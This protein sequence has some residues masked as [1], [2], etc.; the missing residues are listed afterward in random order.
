VPEPKK[1]SET[2]VARRIIHKHLL[3]RAALNPPLRSLD[4]HLD[5]DAL[6]VFIEGRLS[7]RESAPILQHL[8]ACA[9]CRHITAQLVR[10][11]S[12]IEFAQPEAA[13]IPL[14]TSRIRG[15]LEKLADRAAHSTTD[16][17]VF[18]Y[19]DSAQVDKEMISETDLSAND[20]DAPT[21]T[22]DER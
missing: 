11:E 15:F 1:S 7:E 9:S 2:E 16:E 4:G 13:T 18:A 19:H 8:V 5:E 10:L 14:E 17:A 21:K 20:A 3:R 22:E 12:E 6:S